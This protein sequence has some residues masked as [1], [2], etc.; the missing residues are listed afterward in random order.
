MRRQQLC[1]RVL[2]LP[3]PKGGRDRGVFR[4]G[5]FALDA[6]LVP[7]DI[8]EI[9]RPVQALGVDPGFLDGMGSGQVVEDGPVGDDVVDAVE[10]LEDAELGQ[11]EGDVL[12]HDGGVLG[13][14]HDGELG[15]GGAAKVVED[16]GLPVG[17]VSLLA[18]IAHGFFWT[19]HAFLFSAEFVGKT[20]Q[21]PPVSLPLIA[22][23]SEN[24]R[25]V[26]SHVAVFLFGVESDGMIASSVDLA[27]DVEKKGIDVVV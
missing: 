2:S 9:R 16:G 8:R 15:G 10:E 3:V 13:Y 23:E 20:D 6:E 17:N 18:E 21:E 11:R 24:T 26:V 27:H 14:V 25:Q 7:F 4:R 1:R 5:P 22:G 12:H 19:P